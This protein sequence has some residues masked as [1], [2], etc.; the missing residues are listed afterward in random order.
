MAP[1]AA[2]DT[3]TVQEVAHKLARAVAGLIE[4]EMLQWARQGGRDLGQVEQWVRCVVGQVG[5]LLTEGC[6]QVVRAETEG[7]RGCR[8]GGRM[9][10]LGM[11]ERRVVTVVGEVP[12]RR[13]YYYCRQCG[14][15]AHAA[16]GV[17]R[18]DAGM[19]SPGV[20]AALGLFAAILPLRRAVQALALAAPV[21]MSASTCARVARELGE[22][23]QGQ[24]VPRQTPAL[25]PGQR[26]YLAMDGTCVWTQQGWREAKAA[27]YYQVRPGADGEL[28][29][30][31]HPSYVAG[32]EAAEAFGERVYAEGQWR[33][34]ASGRLRGALGDGAAW[35]WNLVDEHFPEAVQV[36][37][38]YHASQRIRQLGAT[39]YGEGTARCRQWVQE[40]LDGLWEQGPA[41]VLCSLQRLR[42]A[43]REAQEA[44]RQ[45]IVYFRN[46]GARMQYRQLRR[47]GHPVGS[48]PVETACKYLIG[49]RCKQPGMRWSLRGLKAILCLR[50][51]FFNDRYQQLIH[52][53]PAAA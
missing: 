10:S 53:L 52:A 37:D 35:I 18:L 13:R 1:D 9:H 23:A 6:V 47:R 14:A 21:R 45:A 36:V 44:V 25:Q 38:W 51:A 50:T 11:R 7:P 15:S 39:L 17:L 5:R 27:V 12:L 46:N 19:T 3:A 16:D 2:L 41:P 31:R 8:C 33:G 43:G 40:R 22:R 26:L 49:T 20:R 30:A 34:V 32:M 4:A 24:E 48:G 29:A 28:E 42:P